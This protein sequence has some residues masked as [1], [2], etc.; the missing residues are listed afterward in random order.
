[1]A[2]P[3]ELRS[4]RLHLR[5]LTAE[6]LPDLIELDSDPEVMRHISGGA[7]NSREVYLE[8]LLPRMLAWDEHPFGFLAAYEAERFQGWFHLRPSV[9]D[10]GVLELGYRLRRAAWGRGLATEGARALL[11]HAFATLHHPAVD[12]CAHPDNAASIHVMVKCGM[13]RVGSFIHPR[14][15]LEVVRYMVERDEWPA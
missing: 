9:A 8:E 2:V 15:P 11:R 6:H 4:E 10:S 7:P 5:R 3:L 12:A 14:I 13:R 1:M